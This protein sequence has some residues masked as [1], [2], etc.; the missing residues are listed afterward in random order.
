V[1]D[2]E[3]DIS[4][5]VLADGLEGRLSEAQLAELREARAASAEVRANYLWLQRAAHDLELIGEESVKEAPEIDV[6][7]AV[8]RAVDKA[9]ASEKT[10]R[11]AAREPQRPSFVFWGRA[12]LAA[13]VL[14]MVFGMV[15]ELGGFMPPE[16]AAP[17]VSQ[18]PEL[19]VTPVEQMAT[20]LPGEVSGSE[21]L[22]DAVERLAQEITEKLDTSSKHAGRGDFLATAAPVLSSV[23]QNDVV[24]LRQAAIS[25]PGAWVRLKRMATLDAAT[26]AEVLENP[27]LPPDAMVGVAASLPDE[28]ARQWLVTAV[29]RMD[30]QKP[31]ARLALA[32]TYVTHAAPT[33]DLPAPALFDGMSE[34]DLRA[35][36][37]EMAALQEADPENAL[38]DALQAGALLRLGDTEGALA[39]LANLQGKGVATAYGLDAARSRQLALAAAGMPQES[40]RMLSAVL[41]G[42]DQYN[43]LCDLARDLVQSGQAYEAQGDPDTAQRIYEATQRL[44]EQV[45]GNTRLSEESLAGIDIQRMAMEGLEALYA[46]RG[47]ASEMERLTSSAL[48]LVSQ[49]NNLGGMLESLDR[50]FLGGGDSSFW[51]QLSAQILE[52]GDLAFFESAP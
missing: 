24:A 52:L 32:T 33:A 4:L 7:E 26:A 49:I 51:S 50:L 9:A 40:A 29:G 28:M 37:A 8:L 43:M 46:N 19:P 15:L 1:R 25:E 42:S 16:P 10:A 2:R 18:V 27:D 38:L 23:T 21:R 48:A 34:S 45:T 12:A 41:A 30:Q 3:Y 11:L 20:A 31:Y 35:F 6:V 17:A 47:L 13:A 5:D 44:G 36:L 22:D 14:A 39:A